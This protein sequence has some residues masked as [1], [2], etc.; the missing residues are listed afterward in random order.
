MKKIIFTLSALAFSLAINAQGVTTEHWPNGN[1][2]SEGVAIGNAVVSASDSKENQARQLSSVIK[3]G[4]WSYWYENGT[5]RAEEYYTNGTMTGIW[6]VLYEDGK[7]ESQIDFGTSKATIFFKDGNKNSE[8]GMI[9]GMIH[10]GAWVGYYEN[11]NKNYQGSYDNA[12]NK[13]GTWTWYDEKGNAT[14][15]QTFN[16]GE[17]TGTKKLTK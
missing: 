17:L 2:K 1:K 7:L 8:G 4:K 11:G 3:D 14:T 16:N 6:K 12:G 10:T 5:L 15:E 13:I 9:N